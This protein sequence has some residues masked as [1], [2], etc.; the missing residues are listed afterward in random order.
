MPNVNG[1]YGTIS[2]PDTTPPVR[3]S[4][5]Y[6]ESARLL[7]DWTTSLQAAFAAMPD[8]PRPSYLKFAA[9]GAL[10]PSYD[11]AAGLGVILLCEDA[12]QSDGRVGSV[13]VGGSAFPIVI[14]RVAEDVRSASAPAMPGVTGATP[15]CWARSANTGVG[16]G[17]LTAKHVL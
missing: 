14:R 8:P 6:G 16:D 11:G 2:L 1:P 13:D 4:G 12:G 17:F 3:A 7:M 5:E 15:T 10:N 9:F